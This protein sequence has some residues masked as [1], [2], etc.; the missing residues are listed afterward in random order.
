MLPSLAT[1][2]SFSPD[3]RVWVYTSSRRL[4]DAEVQQVQAALDSFTSEWTAHNQALKAT[5]EVFE[6]QCIILMVDETQAGASGCSIDKSVHFLEELGVQVGADFFER[7]RFGWTD[8][9]GQPQFAGRTELSEARQSGQI[10][11]Q[12]PML[13]TLVQSR[14]EMLEKWW[15]PFSQSWHRRVV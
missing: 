14:R 7:M 10:T 11:D 5:A 12:T 2:P 8:E 4:N 6:N 9:Q 3:S 15:L 13:N 1:H